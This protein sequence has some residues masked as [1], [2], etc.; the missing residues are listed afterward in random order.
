LLAEA[1]NVKQRR[2]Q[3]A[4]WFDWTIR[5]LRQSDYAGCAE[6]DRGNPYAGC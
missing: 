5:G 1:G 3:A 2:L 6:R 4:A